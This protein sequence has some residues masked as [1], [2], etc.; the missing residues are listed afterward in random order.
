MR[1]TNHDV[2]MITKRRFS[3]RLVRMIAGATVAG[4]LALGGWACQ[5][6]EAQ[7]A[8]IKVSNMVC[9]N[10][11]HTIETALG[12]VDGVKEAKADH[13]AKTVTVRYDAGKV[14]VKGLEQAVSKA[15][16]NAND[17]PADPKAHEALPECCK[18]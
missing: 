15:G 1:Q 17:T 5:K 18:I 6:T 3:M 12:K 8:E 4:A 10:C 7:V 9:D 16:Y 11:V 13:K 14:D 2:K